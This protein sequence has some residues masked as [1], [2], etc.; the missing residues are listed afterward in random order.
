MGFLEHRFAQLRNAAVDL[1]A[2]SMMNRRPPEVAYLG[3]TGRGNLGDEA[4]YLAHRRSGLGS[5]APY[6]AD[7][8]ARLVRPSAKTKAVLL[9]G[10]TLVGRHDWLPRVDRITG[11]FPDALKFATGVGVEDPS[12]TGRRV[13]T[14]DEH[15]RAW[16]TRLQGFDSVSVRGPLSAAILEK[17]DVETRVVGDPAL[18]LNV[19]ISRPVPQR[20]KHVVGIN[21]AQ[22]EDSWGGSMSR[23]V[24]ELGYFVE[25]LRALG[26]S[27]RL[28]SMTAG[29]QMLAEHFVREHP[30]V[31]LFNYRNSVDETVRAISECNVVVGPRL[32]LCILA[33]AAGVPFISVMYKPKCLDF[34]LSVCMEEWSI[35]SDSVSSTQMVEVFEVLSSRELEIRRN[36][37]TNVAALRENLQ[38]EI[39]LNKER[40]QSVAR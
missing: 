17:Y 22:V 3:W 9:G 33:A 37:K 5:M 20:E 29:D 16:S 24:V 34:S 12:F 32:H 1:R 19:P 38:S 11:T 2:V 8:F 21:V 25:R 36:L 13:Y 27:S 30:H 23:Y 28:L 10:G 18:L 39:D 26:V 40:I 35:P 4:I 15:M 7:R 6:P 14:S 31:E